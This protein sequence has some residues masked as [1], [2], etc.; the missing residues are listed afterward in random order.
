EYAD[1]IAGEPWPKSCCTFCPFTRGRDEVLSRF[2]RW[3]HH[4]AF[5]LLMENV[6][7]A[8][9][10]R[11]PLYAS[12]SARSVVEAAGLDK[13]VDLFLDRLS[14]EAHALY[15]VR[16]CRPGKVWHRSVSQLLVGT[17]KECVAALRER[18]PAVEAAGDD[19]RTWRAYLLLRRNTKT[20]PDLEEML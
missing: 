15:L 4:G 20:G 16:R 12:R 9:N 5:V 13:V 8:L 10:P 1:Q 7:L 14:R 2:R 18:S 17:R 19:A 11:M 6:A 3:P